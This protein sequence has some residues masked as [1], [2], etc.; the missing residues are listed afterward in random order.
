M[1]NYIKYMM[2]TNMINKSMIEFKV[3]TEKIS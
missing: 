3:N 1:N 2:R